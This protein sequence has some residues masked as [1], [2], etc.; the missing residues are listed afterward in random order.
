MTIRLIVWNEVPRYNKFDIKSR[1]CPGREAAL[2]R[3]G[4]AVNAETDS[5]LPQVLRISDCQCSA[6]SITSASNPTPAQDSEKMVQKEL[7]SQRVGR[8]AVACL[9]LELT[10]AVVTCTPSGRQSTFQQH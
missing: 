1:G 7:E 2:C 6:L 10:A 9:L 3:A 8:S 4:M 5:K